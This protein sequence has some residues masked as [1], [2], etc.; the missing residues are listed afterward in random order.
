MHQTSDY[1]KFLSDE[2]SLELLMKAKDGL[3]GHKDM[4]HGTLKQ[5]TSRLSKARKLCLVMR[6]NGEYRLTAYGK[7]IVANI[8]SMVETKPIEWM[9]KSID[10]VEDP[11]LKLQLIH[12]LFNKRPDIV[13]SLVED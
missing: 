9:F 11:E 1:F 5:Y 4:S 2:L 13:K 7:L 6:V 10:H 3:K 12:S 8:N